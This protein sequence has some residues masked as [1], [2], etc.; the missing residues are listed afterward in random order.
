[1]TE[2]RETVAASSAARWFCKSGFGRFFWVRVLSMPMYEPRPSSEVA[3]PVEGL[4]AESLEVVPVI[5]S[6]VPVHRLPT[7]P[8]GKLVVVERKKNRL[9]TVV[10]WTGLLALIIV[11]IAAFRVLTFGLDMTPQKA[12]EQVGDE[13]PW[14]AASGT[15]E[16]FVNVYFTTNEDAPKKRAE[17]LAGIVPAGVDVGGVDVKGVTRAQDATVV[18]TSTVGS[19]HF[20]SVSFSYW[21][22]TQ[23]SGAWV[24]TSA[25]RLVASVPVD[26]VNEV[27]APVGA[28]ALVPEPPKGIVA[29]EP[30]DTDSA[31]TAS[32]ADLGQAFFQTLYSDRDLSAMTAPGT[33]LDS[34]KIKGAVLDSVTTWTVGKGGDNRPAE[35]VVK[36]KLGTTVWTQHYSLDLVRAT[37]GNGDRWLVAGL[38]AN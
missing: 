3:A 36:I 34:L 9:W 13:F 15:A 8:Q 32:T 6:P 11:I 16:R 35:A 31:L 24:A 23:K 30:L 4:A 7:A 17:D 1:M 38:N 29:K 10:Q 2:R 27:A 5:L 18:G 33:V 21:I 37:A 12:V 26:L 19:R 25:Q 28:P 22:Y 20:V 14:A